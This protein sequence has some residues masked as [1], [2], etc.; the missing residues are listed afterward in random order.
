[1]NKKRHLGKIA[2]IPALGLSLL[3][4]SYA[5]PPDRKAFDS[6]STSSLTGK[7]KRQFDH[8]K[9]RPEAKRVNAVKSRIEL[10]KTERVKFDLFPDTAVEH[11]FRTIARR[12]AGK[13]TWFGGDPKS[14]SH[15]TMVVDGND[16]TGT[17]RHKGKLYQV[18]AGENGTQIVTEVDESVLKDHPPGGDHAAALSTPDVVPS[19]A[20]STIKPRPIA[21]TTSPPP[22]PSNMINLLVAWTPAAAAAAGN[23]DSLIQLAIDETNQAYRNSGVGSVISVNVVVKGGVNYVESGNM[24]TDLDRFRIKTDGIM[25]EIHTWRDQY[26]A[27][28]A[29]LLIS[30]SQYCGI[31]SNIN[32]TA[33]SAF[34]VTAQSCATGY[35]SFG[36]ELGHLIGLRHDPAMDSSTSPYPYGHGLVNTGSAWRTIMAYN[37]ACASA[38]VN[39]TRIQYFASPSISYNGAATGTAAT[40]DNA[41]VLSER[42]AAFAAFR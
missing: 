13:F 4:S 11:K 2:L 23:I 26:K 38:G 27:D 42:A 20:A 18:R 24:Q 12:G 10:G 41:R 40:N 37:N 25:D 21:L 29:M 22:P 34:A 5:V 14:D 39:C 33:D 35:Y 16:V 15:S 6:V 9:G 19:I 1:M 30:S 7:Q 31:A 36:H 8:E 3:T 28:A 32:V 17:V